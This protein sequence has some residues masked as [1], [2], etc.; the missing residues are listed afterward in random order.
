MI[1]AHSAPDWRW[2]SCARDGTPQVIIGITVA[3]RKMRIG[4]PEDGLDLR[5]GF[6]LRKQV[7][8]DPKIH[9]APVRLRKTFENVP[10]IHT[11]PVHRGGLFGAGWARRCGCRVHAKPRDRRPQWLC[12]LPDPLQQR[13]S[14]GR[15]THTGVDEFH[16]RSVP[17]RGA[18][19]GL[20]I[21]EPGESSQVT[22]V[23]TGQIASVQA[24]QVLACGGR[25]RRFQRSRAEAN[26]GLETARAGLQHHT[27]VMPVGAHE[28]HDRRIRTIQVNEN[29]ACVLISGEGLDIY[30]ASLAVANAQ[31]ADRSRTQQLS[32]R[33]KPL[34]GK[35]T[36]AL[37]VNQTDQ[38]QV[39]GHRRK[40]ATDSLPGQEE[41]TVVHDRN[42][43]I[44]AT[45]RTMN[46]QR[47]ANRVLTVCLT[48]GGRL[49]IKNR[50]LGRYQ[51]LRVALLQDTIADKSPHPRRPKTGVLG[52]ATGSQV[53]VIKNP[54]RAG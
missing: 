48:S 2:K 14:A 30:V 20:L 18:S 7:L 11:A 23:R 37:V 31:K 45:R 28:I 13:L 8:G 53:P 21:G 22:P 41:S 5:S 17:V 44:E 1:V 19:C 50:L 16:P 3:A 34:A 51:Q 47:T 25:H 29:I 52:S 42:F 40:L 4:E 24:R 33:P 9:D 10:T 27:R 46:P 54:F 26:P 35:R 49:N 32:R 15:Q 39:I 6:A 36:A 43:A 12:T 38:I